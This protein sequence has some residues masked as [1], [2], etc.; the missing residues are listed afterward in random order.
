VYAPL[1]AAIPDAPGVH[2]DDT[3]GRVGGAPA[4]LLAF[5][6]AAATVDQVRSRHRHADVQEV[7][8]ADDVGVRGT[9]RGRR[10]EAH[11]FDDGRQH[12]CL[13]HLQRSLR[14][15]L[16]TNTGR[17]RDFGAGLNAR[18]QDALQLWHA[19]HDGSA[20]DVVTDAK[21]LRDERTSPRRDRPLQD[22][23]KQRRRNALGWPHDRGNL[24]RFLTDP[25]SEPTNHRAER[26][27]RPAVIARQVS[28]GSTNSRGTHAFEAFTRVVRK[29]GTHA[30]E[31]GARCS[32]RR[33]LPPVPLPEHPRWSSLSLWHHQAR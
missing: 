4:F 1:R 11:A 7:I 18:R 23:E 15:V 30:D 29:C 31:T 14:D 22:P 32:G 2:T 3:G 8:P 27:W 21:A 28:Q 17:A 9:D 19:Y 12:T 6:T 20:T 25:R 13:A 5:E 26:A 33:P 24:G 16:A 10:D